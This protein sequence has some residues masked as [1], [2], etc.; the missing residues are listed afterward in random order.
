MK[1]FVSMISEVKP[2]INKYLWNL[3]HLIGV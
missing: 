2:K 1:K 3:I